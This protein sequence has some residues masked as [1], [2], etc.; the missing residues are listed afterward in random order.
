M[1]RG[2]GDPG[3]EPVTI[4][5][6]DQDLC[7]RT[8][9]VAPCTAA[10]GT[11][12]A[13]KCYRTRKTCQDPEN[14]DLGLPLAL[15]FGNPQFG[16]F[17]GYNILPFLVSVSTSPTRI[18][19]GGRKGRDGSLGKRAS[20]T[21]VMQDA[22][23]SDNLVDPYLSERTWDPLDRGTFWSKW[24]ARTPYYFGRPI[25]IIEGYRG[26]NVATFT[27]RHYV[28][29][30]VEGPDSSGKVTIRA[31]D[32]LRLADNDVAKVT[33]LSPG[34]LSV[35]IDSSITA[36]VVDGAGAGDYETSD[37]LLRIEDEVI[38]YATASYSTPLGLWT[39]VGA[40]RGAYN[41]TAAA[42]EAD[43]TTQKC[44]DFSGMQAWEAIRE[45]LVTHAGIPGSY[46]DDAAWQAEAETWTGNYKVSR[47]ISAPT[48]VAA[49]LGELCEQSL[50]YIWWD[51]KNQKIR[52][53]AVRPAMPSEV[54]A[55]TEGQHLLQ[56]MTKLRVRPEERLTEVW[57]S[58]DL[59]SAV[60]PLGE[61]ASYLQTRARVD[62]EAESSEQYGVRKIYEL[63]A[64]WLTGDAQVSP[65][66]YRMMSRYRDMPPY[67]TIGLD[68]KDQDIEP[69]QV[70]DITFRGM[71]DETGAPL[72]QRYEV[73]SIE[74]IVPGEKLKVEMQASQ[75]ASRYAFFMDN[76]AGTFSSYS[77]VPEIAGFFCPPSGA[78]AAE[79]F[80]DNSEPYVFI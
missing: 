26:E 12:G 24:L 33:G 20:V 66:S 77:E 27:S 29:D 31:S 54:I 22:P 61:R 49:M 72:K 64:V 5:A 50:L 52:L 3:R 18:N 28:I 16:P 74:E 2:K 63:M 21:I 76:A 67:L 14:Y 80:P 71:V 30:K 70:A 48:G 59:R 32:L 65:L 6:I 69:A 35:A 56:G 9:G 57:I 60:H 68:A 43:A 46:I 47:Q 51:E 19:I 23:H 58:H 79:R 55:L 34:Y 7:S 38:T 1:A 11:T 8:Y 10:V 42:H 45:L 39:F 13:H 78:G 15:L 73:I 40:T 25:R 36:F 44:L 17:P 37:G 75:F 53:R 4:V 62:L 41:T